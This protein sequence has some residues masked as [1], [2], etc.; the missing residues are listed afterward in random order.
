M[1]ISCLVILAQT[2]KHS[3]LQV[4]VFLLTRWKVAWHGVTA[5]SSHW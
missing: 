5:S 4:I 2:A 3:I 1:R